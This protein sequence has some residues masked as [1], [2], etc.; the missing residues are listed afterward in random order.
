MES[1]LGGQLDRY[2]DGHPHVNGSTMVTDTYPNKGRMQTLLRCD[3]KSQSVEEIAEVHHGLRYD[4]QTR[5][6]CTRGLIPNGDIVYFDSVYS[7]KR[8][9]KAMRM[10]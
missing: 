9:L 2:G 4:A 3:L 6:D 8:G 1:A 7:G 5:C 10:Q